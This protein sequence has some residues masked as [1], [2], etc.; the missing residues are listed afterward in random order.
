MPSEND[1]FTKE[2]LDN[3][4]KELSKVFK[5]L[6]GLKM[7]GELILIGGASILLKY[8]FRKSTGDVDAII[9]A[10]SVIK[11]AINI[12]GEKFNLPNG[13]LNADFKNSASYSDKLFAVSKYYKKY[14]NILEVRII[15]GEYLIAMKLMAGRSYKHDLSDIVGILYEHKENNN[16]ITLDSIKNA[17]SYLYGKWEE[18]PEKSRKMIEDVFNDGNYK[19]IYE[20][21]QQKEKIM[22][23]RKEEFNEMFP[24]VLKGV[25]INE[26]LELFD[27]KGERDS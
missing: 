10:S 21:N 16:E 18:I 20:E 26:M 13:W 27:E 19:K 22:G 14:S 11:D 4:L 23:Q 3:Y 2:N 5:K 12:I 7:Q 1:F 17:A 24:G 6:N 15:E 25:N 9:N 8:N